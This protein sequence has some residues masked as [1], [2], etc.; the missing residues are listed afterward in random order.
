MF[1][2][3]Y[4][5]LKKCPIPRHL[6]RQTTNYQLGQ[7]PITTVACD[8]LGLGICLNQPQQQQQSGMM[9]PATNVQ[10]GQQNMGFQC[11]WNEEC[12]RPC[13]IGEFIAAEGHRLP[14]ISQ[15]SSERFCHH[16]EGQY[17][18]CCKGPRIIW[19]SQN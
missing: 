4:C 3:Y 10:L 5:N 7:S 16:T 17:R 11:R 8:F 6:F 13:Q 18:Y 15:G 19:T 14:A 9:V 12:G 1:L 2:I